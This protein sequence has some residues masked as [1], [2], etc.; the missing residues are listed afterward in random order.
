MKKLLF[1]FSLFLLSLGFIW[2]L[3]NTL[4]VF[5]KQKQINFKP[6]TVKSDSTIAEKLCKAI[7][8]ETI[9]SEDSQMISEF[10]RFHSFLQQ[11]FPLLHNHLDIKWIKI[12]PTGLLYRWKGS[13]SNKANL[14]LAAQDVAE[15]N[16]EFI[17]QWRFNPFVGK[18]EKDIIYGAGSNKH[19]FCLLAT[20][21]AWENEVKNGFRPK[22]DLYLFAPADF[23]RP[24]STQSQAVAS[25]FYT[26]DLKF[27]YVLVAENFIQTQNN[28]FVSNDIAYIGCYQK[29][30]V[31]FGIEAAD[32][33]VLDKFCTQINHK[34]AFFSLKDNFSKAFVDYISPEMDFAP[35]FLF[36]NPNFFAYFIKKQLLQDSFL[37]QSTQ[38]E[39]FINKKDSSHSAEIVLQLPQH[40]NANAYTQEW[41]KDSAL[42]KIVSIEK[43]IF[44][45][46]ATPTSWEWGLLE[47][48]IKENNPNTIVVPA[49]AWR[50]NSGGYFQLLSPNVYYFSPVKLA[51][52]QFYNYA[53][54]VDDYLSVENYMQMVAFYTDLL[55]AN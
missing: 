55:K 50:G 1:I 11:N 40:L 25:L 4:F 29:N 3:F 32:S 30:M 41:A 13:N 43:Q 47:R 37:L 23:H 2:A 35:R 5:S 53:R 42:Y 14:W 10:E 6:L 54:S 46:I 49:P 34:T 24:I 12:N 33:N 18:Q 45:N 52:N 19:K 21:Q 22:N 17:P 26:Q 16:L 51:Q 8:Y 31:H 27:Q 20:L 7:R 36:A 39:A 38:I 9:A 15:P 28:P 44:A 48:V